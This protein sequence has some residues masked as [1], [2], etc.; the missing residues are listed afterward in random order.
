MADSGSAVGREGESFSSADQAPA[1]HVTAEQTA[2]LT[3]RPAAPP[4]R[5]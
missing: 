4:F 2:T 5:Y 3:P 1:A